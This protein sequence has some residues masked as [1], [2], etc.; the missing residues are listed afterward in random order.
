MSLKVMLAKSFELDMKLPKEL[1]DLPPPI[2]WIASEKLDGL[3]ALWDFKK[4]KFI[5]RNNNEYSCPPWYKNGIAQCISGVNTDGELWIGRDPEDFEG[6]G[7][8]RKKIP[9][10]EDWIKIKYCIYDFPDLDYDFKDRSKIMK[11]NEKIIKENWNIYRLTLDEKFHKI[12]CPIIILEQIT[13]KSIEHMN[14]F[15]EKVLE[16]KGEGIML[17]HP[18]GKYE[19]KRS[20]RLL[21]Y[22]PVSDAEAVIIGYKPGKGK[23]EGLL[24]AFKCKPLINKGNYQIINDDKKLEFHISGMDDNIRTTYKETHPIGTIINYSYN[25]FTSIGKARFPRFVRIRDDITIKKND[26]IKSNDTI[27]KCIEIFEKLSSYEKANGQNFKSAA[28]NKGIEQFKKLEDDYELTPGNL[29][30]LKGIGKSIIEKTM[31]IVSTGTCPQYEAIK[32]TKD[33]RE[34]FMEIHGVGSVKAKELEKKGFKTIEDLNNCDSI[35]EYLNETQLKGLKYY[36]DIQKRIPYME[37]I[38][39]EKILKSILNKIDDKAEL[40]IAGSFRRGQKTSGDIDVLIKTPSVKN[41]S[42]F[43]KFLDKLNESYMIETLSRGKKKFM[44]ITR[45]ND[46]FRRID[47]MFTKPEEYPFAILY[48]TGSKEFNVKMRSELLEKDL[49]LN[50]YGITNLSTNKKVKHECKTEFEVFK[51]L[52]YDYVNP[53]ER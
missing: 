44:G 10:D 52:E 7:V 14:D 9:I 12:P 1:I 35:D 41:S 11:K 43:D 33:S 53:H 24:G 23:Y 46:T 49:S 48:F 16:K 19:N 5:S 36:K 18:N 32:D 39:H 51:Y 22:K 29:S 30:K 40:T 28:Y 37:I 2:N 21:K 42:I 50:E 4:E 15:Y 38:E 3:R 13:I 45:I 26:D 6:M 47:I 8:A 34:L 20:N 17:K 31:N 25:G 27:K